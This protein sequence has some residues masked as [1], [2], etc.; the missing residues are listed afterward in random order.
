MNKYFIIIVAA[1]LCCT[2]CGTVKKVHSRKQLDIQHNVLD[3]LNKELTMH[4]I[5]KNIKT[6]ED[7]TRIVITKYTPPDSSGKQSID[8]TVQVQKAVKKKEE[9]DTSTESEEIVI[10]EHKEEYIDKSDIKVKEETDYPP[11]VK[12]LE[13]IKIIIVLIVIAY[14]VYIYRKAT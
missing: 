6:I 1:I 12:A 13:H 7:S 10:S 9:N 14:L 2:S 5:A 11:F 4:T 3:S 8:Y